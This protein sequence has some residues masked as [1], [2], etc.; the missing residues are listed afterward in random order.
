MGANFGSLYF[1]FYSLGFGLES[2]WHLERQQPL[3]LRDSQGFFFPLPFLTSLSSV[4]AALS[5]GALW[6]CSPLLPRL[7][8][9]LTAPCSTHI[10]SNVQLCQENSAANK[11]QLQQ[12][13]KAAF[14]WL[15][16]H[17]TAAPRAV[18]A[19]ERD[20][21]TELVLLCN[22]ASSKDMDEFRLLGQLCHSKLQWDSSQRV[23]Q[24]QHW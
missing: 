12:L 22:G 11:P 23:T 7:C 24:C 20:Q 8:S 1:I 4:T 9:S 21:P 3:A 13:G 14:W 17:D 5:A 19:A 16:A 6:P 15:C 10:T 18:L 2:C